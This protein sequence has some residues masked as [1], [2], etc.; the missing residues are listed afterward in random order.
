[1]FKSRAISSHM[2]S[3]ASGNNQ[4]AFCNYLAESDY[5]VKAGVQVQGTIRRISN[6]ERMKRL[7]E[8]YSSS[9]PGAGPKFA[10]LDEL[11]SINADSTLFAL[12]I[13]QYKVVDSRTGRVDLA[14]IP[15]AR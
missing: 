8:A 1:M 12:S 5:A 15:N 9:F 13:E 11:L 6:T 7:V 10:P 14:Y 3:V 4:A 2:S